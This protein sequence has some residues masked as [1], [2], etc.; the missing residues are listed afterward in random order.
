KRSCLPDG[1]KVG[2]VCLSPRGDWRMPSDADESIWLLWADE[3]AEASNNNG[4]SSDR[5]RT[6]HMSNTQDA[7]AFP[8][9]TK[10]VIRVLI[11]VDEQ[12][13]FMPGGSLAVD[14]G[15]EVVAPTNALS[16][17]GV[18]DIIVDTQDDH[19][20]DH[21]S[22]ASQHEGK[23][24]YDQVELS[25]VTQTLWP[26]HCVHGTKGWEFHPDLDRTVVH[27]T[28]PKGQDKRVDSYSGVYDNGRRASDEA[29]GLFPFL[30]KS[31][32]LAEWVNQRAAELGGTEIV[33]D[34]VGLAP[35]FCPTF[36]A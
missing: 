10:K 3:A 23:K 9:A 22:F 27:A 33:C 24:P 15:D 14:K 34:V 12:L 26:D 29:K 7:A 32:G 13:D 5:A 30:G 20:A 25:G 28:F 35:P 8:A 31:T 21:G 1:P 16:R 17:S 11:R 18:Y 36:T 6:S 19:P 2:S 4:G